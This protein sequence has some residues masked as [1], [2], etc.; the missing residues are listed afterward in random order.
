LSG[1]ERRAAEEMDEAIKRAAETDIRE[2]E[3]RA[4]AL[5][6]RSKELE[7]MH[8]EMEGWEGFPPEIAEPT[9]AEQE[10]IRSDAEKLLKTAA[11]LRKTL[12]L[13]IPDDTE[14]H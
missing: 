12:G 5:L 6:D 13:P 2:L 10:R 14:T 11:A 1:D 3:N 7:R 8:E 4:K 9:K